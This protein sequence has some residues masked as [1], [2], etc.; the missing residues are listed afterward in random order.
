MLL[1]EE[2]QE[3]LRKII[4]ISCP[5]SCPQSPPRT[6]SSSKSITRPSTPSSRTNFDHETPDRVLQRMVLPVSH[7]D[8]RSERIQ[9]SC[10]RPEYPKVAHQMLSTMVPRWLKKKR[11]GKVAGKGK[12][13]PSHHP[14]SCCHRRR[15]II[16]ERSTHR[17]PSC[18]Q[19]GS[20]QSM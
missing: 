20:A 15:G 13:C 14:S 1:R 8:R 5:L 18:P 11:P 10:V 3:R 7:R 6:C 2:K 17:Q 9:A 19:R 12:G 4:L 16:Y